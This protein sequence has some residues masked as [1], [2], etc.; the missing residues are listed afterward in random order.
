MNQRR[1]AVVVLAAGRGQRFRGEGHKLEQVLDGES[2]LALTLRQTM[3]SGLPMLVVTSTALAPL[4]RRHVA[5]R[6][7]LVLPVEKML[8]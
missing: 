6:D 1:P 8:A 2:V 4:V 3:A 5:A 7:M